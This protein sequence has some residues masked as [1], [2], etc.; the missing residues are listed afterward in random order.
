M[1]PIAAERVGLNRMAMECPH[2]ARWLA[3]IRTL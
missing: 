2:F 3:Q 1:D